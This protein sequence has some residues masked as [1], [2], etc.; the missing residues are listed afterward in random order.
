MASG[1]D[2]MG[3]AVSLLGRALVQ[4]KASGV[5][6]AAANIAAVAARGAAAVIARTSATIMMPLFG[7]AS[8]VSRLRGGVSFLALFSV[9]ASGKSKAGGSVAARS[10]LNAKAQSGNIAWGGLGGTIALAAKAKS[11]SS[12]RSTAVFGALLASRAKGMAKARGVA[13]YVSGFVSRSISTA[14]GMSSPYFDAHIIAHFGR[15][16]SASTARASIGAIAGLF[17]RSISVFVGGVRKATG[18]LKPSRFVVLARSRV[19]RTLGISRN[20]IAVGHVGTMAKANDLTPPIDATV[21]I[22]TITF[23]FSQLLGSATLTAIQ[24][25]TCALA[26]GTDVTPTARLVGSP[27]ISTSAT[28]VLQ[29]IGNMQA[30]A[31]YRLQCVAATSDNQTLSIWTHISCVAPS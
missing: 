17:G 24:S 18:L 11:V 13:A 23:D 22:E 7:R 25:V 19:L 12:A 6:T 14:K 21:E 4:S 30:G 10:A 2:A 15:A 31:R 29:Q 16:T 3:G 28:S 9:L 27:E 26:G 5:A 1:R 20:R 8:G